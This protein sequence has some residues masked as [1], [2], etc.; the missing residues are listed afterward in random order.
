VRPQLKHD[1]KK[2]DEARGIFV[3][4]GTLDVRYLFFDFA[5]VCIPTVE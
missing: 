2:G 5:G 4:D 1:L 3:K